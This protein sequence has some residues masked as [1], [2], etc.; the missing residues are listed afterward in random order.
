M[1]GV[2]EGV[3]PS[4]NPPVGI[5]IGTEPG[6]YRAERVFF[7]SIEQVRDPGRIYEID[8]MKDSTD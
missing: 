6:E 7:C 4:R 2:R 1:F 8:L 5:F 3:P